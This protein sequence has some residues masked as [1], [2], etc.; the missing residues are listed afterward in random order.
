MEESSHRTTEIEHSYKINTNN[1]NGIFY[2]VFFC[3]KKGNNYGY[4]L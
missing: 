4:F 2:D 1:L 3:I